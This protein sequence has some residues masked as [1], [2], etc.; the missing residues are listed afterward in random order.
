MSKLFSAHGD[1][2]AAFPDPERDVDPAR[3]GATTAILAGGCFWCTEAVFLPLDGVTH[4]TSGYIGGAAGTASYQAVCSGTTGH[5]EAI[6]VGFD[7][8]VIT[9][10][11]LLK[12]FFAV[13]HDPTQLNRQGADRGTQYRSAIFPVDD[14]QRAV[15]TAYVAQLGEAAVFADP[16]VTTIEPTQP[17]YPAEAYHQNYAARNPAQPYVAA[18]ALPKV[19]KLESAFP[20]KLRKAQG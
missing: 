9:F 16:I 14:E 19:A 11:Q 13:A 1:D 5:A 2:L 15:A 3:S 17:F 6:E 18:V 20:E 10:G 7:P 4:V 12:V 8:A